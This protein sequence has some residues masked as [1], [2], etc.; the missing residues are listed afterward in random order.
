MPHLPQYVAAIAAALREG[1]VVVDANPPC[2]PR[3]LEYQ[4]VDTA[5]P[6]KAK[7]PTT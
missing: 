2:A 3:E 7:S 5:I 4:L 6:K 1:C